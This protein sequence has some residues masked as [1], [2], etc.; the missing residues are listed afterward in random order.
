MSLERSLRLN[1]ALR[2]ENSYGVSGDGFGVTA[3]IIDTGIRHSHN[4]FGGRA[5]FGT[6]AVGD[7]NNEDCNGHGA[8]VAGTIG[9]TT[10]GV[11][12]NVDLVT[13]AW[14]QWRWYTGWCDRRH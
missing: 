8:H 3:Y 1:V 14:L 9:G 6:N 13:G 2:L 5:S 7:G 12:K 10:Y 11:T 4:E